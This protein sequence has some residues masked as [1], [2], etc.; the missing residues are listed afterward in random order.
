LI[1]RLKHHPHFRDGA[2]ATVV[3]SLALAGILAA[4]VQSAGFLP[5]ST[6]VVQLGETPP[7]LSALPAPPVEPVRYAEVPR[8]DAVKINAAIP[9]SAGPNPAAKPFKLAL[10][11]EDQARSIDCLAAAAYYEAATEGDDGMRAVAQVVINRLRHPA[12]P[13]TVCGVV[14]QGSERTTGCQFTFTC[15]GAIARTPSIGGWTRAR[16]IAAAALKGKVYKPVGHST[17]YHTNWVVPYWSGSLDKVAQIGTHLFFRWQGWW[18]TP[19]AFRGGHAG[20]E[21]L[22]AKMAR[23]S[24]AHLGAAETMV[25]EGE[26]VTP[27]GKLPRGLRDVAIA[28]PGGDAFI[29]LLD[30]VPA[31]EFPALALK[32]CGQKEFCK[33]LGWT[34][35][36][37]APKG[38]PIGDAEQKALSF[39]YLR[40]KSNGFE[41]MLW[42]CKEFKR[43]DQ[44][45]CMKTS[46]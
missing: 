10:G 43:S 9:F 39:S 25:A 42:N 31:N 36:G 24:P 37:K 40:N 46:G 26:A 15:D 22:V 4:Q 19:G 21:Q 23:L 16:E 3:G 5:G 44:A 45:Q 14:F 35:P 17:H 18:G 7:P 38:F 29:V 20:M 30:I 27:T 8:E 12:F 1:A 28:S 13:K 34:D 6:A 33:F 32:T 41:K 11:A 2:A